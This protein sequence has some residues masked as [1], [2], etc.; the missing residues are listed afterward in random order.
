[1]NCEFVSDTID[2][3]YYIFT[4]ETEETKEK[5][6]TPPPFKTMTKETEEIS[7]VSLVIYSFTEEKI[8]F[9]LVYLLLI[10]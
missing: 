4:E 9:S 6:F 3:S 1:M 7:S 8:R 2:L 10:P 5:D